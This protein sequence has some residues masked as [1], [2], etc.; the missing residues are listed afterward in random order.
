MNENVFWKNGPG[1]NPGIILG[2]FS[3]G[4]GKVSDEIVLEVLFG[5]G[6]PSPPPGT[7]LAVKRGK[8]SFRAVVTGAVIT[9]ASNGSFIR[10]EIT[11][12][13]A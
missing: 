11:V 12:L 5:S 6:T 1:R 10:M 2:S 13:P 3:R 7:E 9:A 4:G 8:R